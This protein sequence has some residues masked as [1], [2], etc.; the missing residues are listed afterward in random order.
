M[1]VYSTSNLNKPTSAKKRDGL[2]PD[3]LVFGKDRVTEDEI[4]QVLSVTGIAADRLRA[5]EQRPMGDTRNPQV[6]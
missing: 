2:R 6:R 4:Q 3:N 1:A 5:W